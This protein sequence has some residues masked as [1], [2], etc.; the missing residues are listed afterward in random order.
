MPALRKVETNFTAGEFTP[1]LAARSDVALYRNGAERLRDFRLS[2]Q[3]GASARF[4]TQYKATLAYAP[5]KLVSYVFNV[6]QYYWFAFSDTRAEIFDKDGALIQTLTGAPWSAA[7]LNRLNWAA[8]GDTMIVVHPDLAIQLIQRTG[9]TSFA[10]SAFAFETETVAGGTKVKQ[11]YF[12][13]AASTMTLTPSATTGTGITLTLSAPGAWVAG[14]VGTRVRYKG[15]QI[16]I[17][18]YTSATVATG[19]VIETLP[20]TT[21]ETDW[22]EQAF[23][24]VRGYPNSVVWFGD[25]LWFG[26]SKSHP[27]GLWGSKVGSYFNFDV[28]SAAAADAIWENAPATLLSE[29]RHLLDFRHLLVYGDRIF[30][31]VP[32]SPDSPIKPDTIQIVPQQPYGASYVRPQ[33]FDG[34]AVYIQASGLVAREGYW[35]DTDQAYS[36]NVISGLAPHL[37]SAPTEIAAMY[38]GETSQAESYLFVVNGDGTLSVFH[39]VRAEK[40]AAWVKWSTNGTFKGVA[41]GPNRVAV[42][43]ERALAAGTVTA[44]EF[45]DEARAPLDCAKRA[46][47]GSPTRTFSGFSYLDGK[48]VDVVTKGHYLGQYVPA[49]GNIV[50][51]GSDPAVTEIEAGFGYEPTL[52][53]MPVDF[54]LADGPARGLMK[55]LKR[56]LLIVNGITGLKVQGRDWLPN[57]RGDDYATELAGKTGVIEIRLL[58]LSREAQFDVTIP[59]GRKGTILGLTRDV[60]V[61]G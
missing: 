46:T 58:G 31:Y 13:F 23:S 9:A 43:V 7:M 39:S 29:I 57:F 59:K 8:Q 10:R 35:I 4:G 50:L 54:D 18:G 37:V 19:D 51:K 53:P 16:V 47:S 27:I 3:G 32:S 49:G 12:K 26:G 20:G 48:T 30:M 25:R 52:R 11:P 24:T 61:A 28:G 21:A 6:D 34:A 40:M 44:L 1:L 15:K 56:A 42:L 2:F 41:A 55:R 60:Y 33:N 38:G 14:H 22:D 5:A 17:T 45:F 36:A